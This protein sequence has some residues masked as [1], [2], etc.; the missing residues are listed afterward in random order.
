[1]IRVFDRN[2]LDQ[3]RRRAIASGEATDFLVE[4]AARDLIERLSLVQRR[5]GV[6][7]DLGTPSPILADML[8]ASGQADLVIRLART[9][10]DSTGVP[11]VGGDEEALPFRS[12]SL[13]LVVSA[14]ALQFVNDLPGA[15]AQIRRALR[16]DGLFLASLLGAETLAELRTALAEAESA[17]TGGAAPRV[18]PFAD[19]AD[20]GGLLQRAGFALPVTDQDRLVV[21]YDSMLAL[22]KD[23][24]RMGATNALFERDRRPLRRSVLIRAAEIYQE[25]F[26]DPDGRVRATFRVLSLSGWA[27]AESQQKPLRPG[28]AKARLADALGTTERKAGKKTGRQG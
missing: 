10:S 20:V 24:R 7:L 19:L 9:P 3:R 16:P 1:M 6:A 8:R 17:I 14:L 26:A 13:D 18:A 27:P 12:E 25:R 2:L 23:L 22:L 28:S 21:R 5:F 4:A 11:V 15:L